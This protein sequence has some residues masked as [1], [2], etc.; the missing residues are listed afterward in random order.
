VLESLLGPIGWDF[1]IDC[2]RGGSGQFVINVVV[3]FFDRRNPFVHNLQT[4]ILVLIA[5]D[6]VGAMLRNQHQKLCY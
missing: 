1:I 5:L 2:G 4:L 3:G 6:P